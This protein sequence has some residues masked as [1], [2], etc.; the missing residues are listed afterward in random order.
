MKR[1]IL[2]MTLASI[3]MSCNNGQSNQKIEKHGE[4]REMREVPTKL[5]QEEMDHRKAEMESRKKEREDKFNEAWAEF[6]KLSETEKNEWIAKQKKLIDHRDSLQAAKRAE[7]ETKWSKFDKSSQAEQIE[8]LKMRGVMYRKHVNHEGGH[9]G[10]AG[11]KHQHE[12]P[13][14]PL[15][16][17][18]K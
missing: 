17:L 5:S 2:A 16:E 10:H 7:M 18:Q 4:S 1:I 9:D 6:D 8:L 14:F 11:H 13:K 3:L 12:Q 15:Q